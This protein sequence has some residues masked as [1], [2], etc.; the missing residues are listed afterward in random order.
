MAYYKAT[1]E[2]LID[3]PDDTD[4][5]GYCADAISET[6][7]PLLREFAGEESCWIDWR[8]L[9]QDGEYQYASPHNGVGFE[10]SE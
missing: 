6:M 1:V 8:Y 9:Y 3:V 5:E 10:Y 2:I 4:A 7:R